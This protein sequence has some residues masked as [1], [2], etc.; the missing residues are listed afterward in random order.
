MLPFLYKQ[1]RL[2]VSVTFG[3]QTKSHCSLTCHH[4]CCLL[5]ADWPVYCLPSLSHV[6]SSLPCPPPHPHHT[7]SSA[8]ELSMLSHPFVHHWQL[9]TPSLLQTPAHPLCFAPA[10]HPP[11]C[12]LVPLQFNLVYRSFFYL[13][14]TY[15]H[16]V[17]S[18]GLQTRYCG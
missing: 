10:P 18:Q 17:T 7:I 16:H 14:T 1:L 8:L 4:I 13:N 2:S 12:L 11:S 3:I 5:L 6:H 15:F 9:N